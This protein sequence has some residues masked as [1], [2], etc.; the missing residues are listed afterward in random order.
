MPT[1]LPLW[2]GEAPGLHEAE[3]CFTPTITP[4][5]VA[6]EAPVGAVIVLPGGGY[7]GRAAHE[8]EPISLMF[9]AA[10]LASFVCDYRV[11]PYRHPRPWEDASRAV[12]WVRAHAAEYGVNPQ[13]VG[14][15]GFSAGGHLCATVGTHHDAGDPHAEEAVARQSCRPDALVLCYA[16][17]SFG[18]FGHPGSC[19]NLLGENPSEDLVRYL[20]N[21]TQVTPDT[22]PSFLWHTTDDGG[23]PVQ[24]SLA[25]AQA[26]AANKVDFELHSY[27]HGRHGLG[28]AGDDAHLATWSALCCEWLHRLGF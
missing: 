26:L 6:T 8:G 9:N 21:E 17:I 5:P 20:S 19:R 18:A 4:Y 3:P 7:S 14:L 12:R 25:F 11:A 28:L 15:L 16:V 22:P 13:K 2:P 1:A 24:N 10:G 27:D 23:V